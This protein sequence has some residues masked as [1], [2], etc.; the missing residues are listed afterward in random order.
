MITDKN[1]SSGKAITLWDLE[2]DVYA[3][4]CGKKRSTG[5]TSTHVVVSLVFNPN[6]DIK[7]LAVA[8]LDGDLALLDP[9]LDQQLECFRANCQALAASPNGRFLAAGGANG[10]VNVYEFDTFNLLYRVESSNSFIKQ[11]A[12]SKDSMLLADIR[13]TQCT[14]W[15][16]E[17][18]LRESLGDD[19]SRNTF[20]SVV[21]TVSVE[22]KA[23]ITAMAVH[24]AS[25]IIFCGKDDGSVALYKRETG[26]NLRTLYNHKSA[27]RLLAWVEDRNALLSVDASNGILLYTVQ[28]F[29]E[30]G[31]LE[32]PIEIFKSR[33]DYKE[34][35][36]DVLVGETSGRLL[37][38][39]RESDHM[40]DLD[41]G[42][43]GQG[44]KATQTTGTR[45]WLPHPRSPLH[46]VC[47]EGT[48]VCT[49]CWNDWSQVSCNSVPL[50][51][52]LDLKHATLFCVGNKHG[53]MVDLVRPSNSVNAHTVSIIN[54]D[55][56]A[57]EETSHTPSQEKNHDGLAV[58]WS[59]SGGRDGNIAMVSS[60]A[61]VIYPQIIPF[62]L[63]IAHV[64]GIHESGRLVFLNRCSWVCSINLGSSSLDN[65]SRTNSRT[66][67]VTEHFFV[68]YDWFAGKKDI[69]CALTKRD[70]LLTRGG[71]LAV[72]RGGLAYAERV[73][74]E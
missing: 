18:L 68:P 61:T 37:V 12:F 24:S 46:L 1:S 26:A 56:L 30:K 5:E 3:G 41:S 4:S 10:I 71:D 22:A 11:L 58:S 34:A 62:Q 52:S 33:L 63:D 27:I 19:S 65:S 66:V 51:S 55:F 17:A 49:Y 73:Y 32:D 21:E 28:D 14:V 43:Y 25:D 29:A 47:V 74:V 44:R 13:G 42:K 8:Y 15:E 60:S 54:A 31:W 48:E 23:T 72:V 53:I 2:E 59:S 67:E 9:F 39:T 64:I 70:I 16:P 45:K 36:I 57:L 38:S 69:V 50:E 20:T 40:F 7:L 6:P 35:I